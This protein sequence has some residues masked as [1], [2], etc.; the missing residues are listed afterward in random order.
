MV[1]WSAWAD[2]SRG[3][4]LLEMITVTCVT[5]KDNYFDAEQILKSQYT[6]VRNIQRIKP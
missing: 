2:F 6:N 3:P 1:Y 5:Q 4:G